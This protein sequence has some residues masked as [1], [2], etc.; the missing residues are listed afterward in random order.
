MSPVASSHVRG[1][2]PDV[3][4]RAASVPVIQEGRALAPSGF[5]YQTAMAGV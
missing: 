4:Q 3:P 5:L 1:L 2:T